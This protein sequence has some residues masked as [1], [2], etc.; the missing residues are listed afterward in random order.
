[1]NQ[2]T[3]SKWIW[4]S[5]GEIP[6]SYAEFRDSFAY[7]G[8]QVWMRL[9]CDTDYTLYVNGQFAASNQYGD[10]EHYKIYDSLDITNHLLP[11]ENR[12]DILVY[13]CGVD[14]QR[15]RK[16]GAGLLYEVISDDRIL[17]YSHEAILSRLSPTYEN[18]QCLLVTP[19]LGFTFAYDATRQREEG[20]T[21]SVCVEKNC[22]LYPRPVVKGALLPRHAVKSVTKYDDTHY[23]ID[24]GEEVVGLPTLEISS[25]TEQ[26]IMVA[27]GEHIDDGCV[28][29]DHHSKHFYYQYKTVTG[30]N[31]FTNYMLR[32][33]GRYLE[34]FARDAIE[35]HYVGII[36]QV[37]PV[38]EVPCRFD[39]E[40]DRRIYDV[41][42]NTMKLCMMEHYVDCPWRE[43]N[44]YALD[45]RNQMLFGYYAFE[46][47][48][49]D[50]ARANLKL[51]GEDRRSDRLMSICY[52]CGTSLA[53]PSYAL[54][55]VMA[56]KEYLIYTGD[57]SLAV[58]YFDR[59]K[60]ILDTFLENTKDGLVCTLPGM[61]NYYDSSEFANG[62]IPE[63]EQGLPDLPV[64]C[65]VVMALT[66]FEEI[67]RRIGIPY[68][69]G[70]RVQSLQKRIKEV[71]YNPERGLFTMNAGREQYTEL[72]NLWAIMANT[73]TAEEAEAICDR[74]VS[75]AL[76][77]ISLN[78]KLL[79]YQVLMAVNT[80][81]YRDHIL[82]EIRKNYNM[83]LDAGSTTVWETIKGADDFS[84]N[85]SMCHAW[86]A[87]PV[88]VYHKLGIAK[89]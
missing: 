16:A 47:G 40:E 53:I 22:Q 13:Y 87:V 15:Y 3:K 11:G 33:A 70:D 73:V 75:G 86:S 34:V 49:A 88:Y 58:E 68:P 76:S 69:Y 72:F 4:I 78:M 65:L 54:H 17:S 48:N 45:A 27:W 5:E 26:T 30:Q 44:L 43:Q 29:K 31:E 18:G 10:F 79:K 2:F 36:P 74:I 66:C 83:M 8:G 9:S 62:L 39:S 25:D 89:K 20:Y 46:G 84:G 23:L 59:M 24:L 82:T 35:L 55:Y 50:Y 41:C 64:N 37:I 80:D 56:M 63:S 19:Q 51:M 67:C 60:G 32:I 61:W 57:T 14:N 7:D 6:D 1:M 85:G 77:E 52:P 38:E 81:K 71:F 28:R 42:V 21:P 12:I